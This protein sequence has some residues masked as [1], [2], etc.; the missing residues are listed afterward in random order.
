MYQPAAPLDTVNPTLAANP[1]NVIRLPRSPRITNM[2]AQC[3]QCLTSS[4]G[5]TCTPQSLYDLLCISMAPF[6]VRMG[7]G[8]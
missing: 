2:P 6:S 4:F 3:L 1:I 8:E 5:R 7:M